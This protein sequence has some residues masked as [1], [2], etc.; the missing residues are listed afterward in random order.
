MRCWKRA[1]GNSLTIPC[2][3][4]YLGSQ[5][6]SGDPWVTFFPLIRHISN[7]SSQ[8]S[9][10]HD[11]GR[12]EQQIYFPFTIAQQRAL[13]FETWEETGKGS[14]AYRKAQVSKMTFSYWQKCFSEQSYSGREEFTSRAPNNLPRFPEGLVPDLLTSSSNV[15]IGD[16]VRLRTYNSAQKT[17]NDGGEIWQSRVWYPMS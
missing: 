3:R 6:A 15:D 16:Q 8:Y 4:S 5:G 17:T 11:G 1:S 7:I 2:V 13:L 12:S 14:R 10:G 9:I